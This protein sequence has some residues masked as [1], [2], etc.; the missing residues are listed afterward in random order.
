MTQTNSS[1]IAID[2][3]VIVAWCSGETPTDIKERLD[4]LLLEAHR[5]KR[6]IIIPTPAMAEFL[7]R[8]EDA[9]TAAFA[10][11]EKKAAVYVAPFDRMAAF[12]CALLDAAALNR[13]DKRDGSTEPYQKIKI[14]RQII[15][16]A[17]VHAVGLVITED[18]GVRKIAQRVGIEAKTIAELDPHPQ[19]SL[20]LG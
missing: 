1:A 10:A 12:E 8:A 14:D 20:S 19:S 7:V 17:K 9:S 6:R 15:A 4:Q 2:A 16:I 5:D 11:L 18:E 13:G 3:N